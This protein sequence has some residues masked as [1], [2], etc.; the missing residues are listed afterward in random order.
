MSR[1]AEWPAQTMS[2]GLLT[3][4]LVCMCAQI[5]GNRSMDAVF[6]DVSAVVDAIIDKKDPLEAFCRDVPEADECRVY[7]D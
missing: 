7:Q 5:D 6:A 4:S 2:G 3:K 1:C